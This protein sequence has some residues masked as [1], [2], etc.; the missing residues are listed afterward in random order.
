MKNN[1]VDLLEGLMKDKMLDS[2]VRDYDKHKNQTLTSL[3]VDSLALIELVLRIETNFNVSI[4]YDELDM[5]DLET[6]SKLDNYIS[7]ILQK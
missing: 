1:L 6:L 5:N 4:D 2:V 7:E 3:G